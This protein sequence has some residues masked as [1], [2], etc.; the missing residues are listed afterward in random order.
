MADFINI[1][2]LAAALIEKLR[3]EFQSGP[4][5][6]EPLAYTVDQ[7]AKRMNIGESTLRMM[8]RNREIKVI[9]RGTSILLRRQS[10]LDWLETHEE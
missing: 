9:R 8:I 10:V 7:A 2:A 4:L 6:P 3:P 1:D 5:E